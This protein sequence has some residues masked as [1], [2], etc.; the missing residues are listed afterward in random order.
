MDLGY[1]KIKIDIKSEHDEF[2]KKYDYKRK[3]LKREEIK[4]VFDSF[5]DFFKADGHFKFKENEHSITAE[6]K[7]H[8]IKLDMDIYKNIDSE[9]FD[10]HGVIKTFEKQTHDFTVQGACTTDLTLLPPEIDSQERMIYDT[11]FYKEFINGEVEYVFQY[12]INGRDKTY[13][14]MNELLQAL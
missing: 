13:L 1:L 6:Y 2:K 11:R 5:K 10:L 3:E 12:R 14:S 4:K 8:E 9:D 7:E